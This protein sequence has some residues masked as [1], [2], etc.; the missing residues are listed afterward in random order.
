MRKFILILAALMI[1]GTTTNCSK[2]AYSQQE[3]LMLTNKY[4]HPRNK[5]KAKKSQKNYKKRQKTLNKQR[6]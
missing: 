2:R 5:K 6:R 1:V 3:G 4:N